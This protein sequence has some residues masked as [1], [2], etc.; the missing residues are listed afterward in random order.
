MKR[1]TAIQGSLTGL[2]AG[3]LAFVAGVAYVS[4]REPGWGYRWRVGIGRPEEISGFT[5]A[6]V[7]PIVP[8]HHPEW[9]P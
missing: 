5:E 2:K 8:L 4:G 9:T 3:S 7:S 1:L 6:I